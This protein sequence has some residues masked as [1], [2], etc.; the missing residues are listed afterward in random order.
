LR[1]HRYEFFDSR[2][3]FL[4]VLLGELYVVLGQKLCLLVAGPSIWLGIDDYFVIGHLCLLLMGYLCGVNTMSAGVA[5]RGMG[6]LV[7]TE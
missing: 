4:D 7:G 2:G 5:I 3:I 6:R 1:F